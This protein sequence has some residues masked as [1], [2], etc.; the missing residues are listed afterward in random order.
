MQRLAVARNCCLQKPFLWAGAII[1]FSKTLDKELSYS[2]LSK[3]ANFKGK[4]EY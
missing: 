4:I 1:A 3:L 2:R